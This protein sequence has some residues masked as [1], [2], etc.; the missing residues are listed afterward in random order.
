MMNDIICISANRTDI[1][2]EISVLPCCHLLSKKLR[3]KKTPIEWL[4]Y[5]LYQ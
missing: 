5:M 1:S 3:V 4:L 2:N